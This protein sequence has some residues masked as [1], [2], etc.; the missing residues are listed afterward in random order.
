MSALRE[1]DSASAAELARNRAQLLADA[2]LRFGASLDQEL[3]YAA[4]ATVALPGPGA[5][6][7]VDV[8]EP[9]GTLRR[10]DVV[11]PDDE[12]QSAARALI[13][14]WTPAADDPIGVPAIARDRLPIVISERAET[15][16]VA[17]ARD[18]ET[19]RVLR[20]LG[21][22]ALLVVPI[23][24][25]GS[26]LGAITFVGQPGARSYHPDEVAFAKALA[27]RCAQA[28]ESA[29]LYATARAALADADAARAQAESAN[30]TKTKFLNTMSHELRTPLNAIAGYAQLMELGIHGPVTEEQKTDLASIQRSQAHLLGLVNAVL[31]FAQ[32][33]AGYVVYAMA[34]IQLIDIVRDAASLVSPQMHAKN[35]GFSL[36]RCD[37]SLAVNADAAKVRQILLNLLNNAMKFTAPGGSIT[38]VCTHDTRKDIANAA[39]EDTRDLPR[40][41]TAARS[42]RAVRVTDSGIGISP[43]DLEAIF[44]PFVQ[45]NRRLT[46]SDSGVGLG[47]AISRDLARGMGGD[48]T[49]ESRVGAGSTF[50]LTLPAA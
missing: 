24:A 3:T 46:S 4:I 9:G 28:L 1:Q 17:A 13:G 34:K 10:L 18:P 43:S 29:R 2:G 25:H 35:I 26:L 48:L 41:V 36:E 37:E 42:A 27:S 15:A 39:S 16:V 45:V 22:G 21:S 33:E 20:W 8:I 38:V 30:E 50:T 44:N 49:V 12:K 6:C 11:H 7:I 14:R 5:W 32:L 19:L 40:E 23:I 47:L 31:N